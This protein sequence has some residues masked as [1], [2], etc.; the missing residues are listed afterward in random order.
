MNDELD[1]GFRISSHCHDGSCVAVAPMTDGSIAVRDTK[2]ADQ[3]PLVYTRAEWR[4]FILG[5]KNGEFDFDLL[6]ELPI[7]ATA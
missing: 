4:D 7:D 1:P 6:A 5:V 2:H 3:V